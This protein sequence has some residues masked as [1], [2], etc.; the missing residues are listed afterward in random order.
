[1]KKNIS[2]LISL[3]FGFVV[4][5]QN[6]P[7]Q[8]TSSEERLNAY[9]QRELLEKESLVSQLNFRSIGPTVMSGRVVDFCVKPKNTNLFY[10]AFS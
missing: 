6:N 7:Y 9:K 5:A 3:L 8:Q 1:M 4:F 10:L 2:L